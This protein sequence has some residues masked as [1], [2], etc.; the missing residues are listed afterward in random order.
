MTLRINFL[1]SAQFNGLTPKQPDI[2]NQTPQND[3]EPAPVPVD[4]EP[5]LA[6]GTTLNTNSKN[7]LLQKMNMLGQLNMVSVQNQSKIDIGAKN[8]SDLVSKGLSNS[9]ISKY[10]SKE[11]TGDGGSQYVLNSKYDGYSCKAQFGTHAGQP[12]THIFTVWTINPDG[13]RKEIVEYINNPEK[14]NK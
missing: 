1:R 11:K 10:F 5:A 4:D 3:V 12:Y 13:S 14:T 2:Q 8:Y 7:A 6:S 9:I